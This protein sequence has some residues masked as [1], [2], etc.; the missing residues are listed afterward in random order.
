MSAVM[1]EAHEKAAFERKYLG[2]WVYLM[3]DCMLFAG[4][5]ATFVVL[6]GATA[7]GPTGAQ[8]FDL[9]FVLTETVL[10]LVSSFTA[11]LAVL[12]LG[13]GRKLLTMLLL[14]ATFA[15]G[16]AFLVM[17]LTEFAHL[18]AE[19]YGPDRSAFLSAF[20]TLVGTH[21]AHIAVGLLWLLVLGFR[22]WR[23]KFKHTD[24]NRLKIWALFWHFLD[25]VWIFV[26]TVVYL[27]GGMA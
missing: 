26:F 9:S 8:L 2:F 4:L 22:L 10:L 12:A 27:I 20:F 1:P 6:Q 14:S 21:G 17:E 24:L 15:L 3:T 11:G 18:I 13:R 23:H 5:F 19:G 16:A 7:G 25:V